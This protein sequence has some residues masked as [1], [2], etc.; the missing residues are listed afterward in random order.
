MFHD[1]PQ[2]IFLYLLDKDAAADE[3]LDLSEVGTPDPVRTIKGT[4][5]EVVMEPVKNKDGVTTGF[6]AVVEFAENSDNYSFAIHAGSSSFSHT[7]GCDEATYEFTDGATFATKVD[8]ASITVDEPGFYYIEQNYDGSQV[9]VTIPETPDGAQWDFKKDGPAVFDFGYTLEDLFIYATYDEDEEMFTENLEP[10]PKYYKFV[11]TSL[12]EG[13]F[14]YSTDK[15]KVVEGEPYFTYS[16]FDGNSGVLNSATLSLEDVEFIKASE[17]RE[18]YI[19]TPDGAQWAFVTCPAGET[20]TNEDGE[21]IDEDGNVIN[22]D[23]FES[24]S[25]YMDALVITYPEVN[26]LVDMTSMFFTVGN[27]VSEDQYTSFLPFMPGYKIIPTDYKSGEIQLLNVDDEGNITD[28]VLVI[29]PY[30][31]LSSTTCDFDL[32]QIGVYNLVTEESIVTATLIPEEDWITIGAG[33]W[34]PLI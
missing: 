13:K 27:E 8:G 18:I 7:F 21:P 6:E 28:E 19:P 5:G 25:D 9:T 20:L 33:G 23:D 31:N 15:D 34:G 1:V 17:L 10:T 2:C 4:C 30:S 16:E 3:D 11:P 14:Y 26:M 29:V 24:F 12:T 22:Y 32:E